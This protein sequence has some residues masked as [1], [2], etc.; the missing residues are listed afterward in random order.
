MCIFLDIENDGVI[1]VE[2]QILADDTSGRV[3][4]VR[5]KD[6]V[7]GIRHNILLVPEPP[8]ISG[9]LNSTHIKYLTRNV[10]FKSLRIWATSDMAVR[11]SCWEDNG[12]QFY[13]NPN[14]AGTPKWKVDHKGDHMEWTGS[15]GTLI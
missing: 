8:I 9:L 5:D 6:R 13:I 2:D 1:R 14:C 15:V 12:L 10:H 3:S 11:G 4:L 7:L